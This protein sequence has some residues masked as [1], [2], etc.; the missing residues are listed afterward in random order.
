MATREYWIITPEGVKTE[1]IDF[2]WFGG[3][4]DVRKKMCINSLHNAILERHPDAKILEISSASEQDIG[5]KLSAMN[6]TYKDRELEE[7]VELE[8]VYQSSKILKEYGPLT[9]ILEIDDPKSAKVKTKEL[10]KKYELEGF[11]R[12]YSKTD[13]ARLFYGG[14]YLKSLLQNDLV[15]AVKNLEYNVF[16]DI[17]H[18]TGHACQAEV[19]AEIVNVFG[20]KQ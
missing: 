1:S 14:L 19:V 6:L 10:L 15:D 5:V 16:T 20:K 18:Q 12:G 13:D 8:K 9:E 3:F 17:F 11:E 4:A 2:E 7:P